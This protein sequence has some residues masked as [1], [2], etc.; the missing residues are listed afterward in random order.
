M[1]RSPLPPVYAITDRILSGVRDH[2]AIAERLF[3]VGVRLVQLRE[4]ESPDRDF[5]SAADR[6]VAAA[7]PYGARVVV[8]DRPDVAALSG[9]GV[10]LGEEDLP[11]GAARPLLAP[12]ALLGVS[13]HDEAAAAEAFRSDAP[14]YV[15]FGPVFPSG[16]KTL[17]EARGL[18]VLARVAAGKNRP[19]VAI[20]GIRPE[21]LRSVLDAGADSA[22]MVGALMEGGRLEENARR[23]LDEA[24]RGRLRGRIYLVGFMGSGKT[25]VG[26]RVAER[27]QVP[28]V[29]IDEEVE[30]T[31][32]LTV[33][34]LFEAA[35]EEEF[36]RRESVFLQG[37]ESIPVAVVAT[38]GGSFVRPENRERLRKLGTTVFLDPPFATIRQRLAGKTDRPLFQNAEQAE[39]LF[40]EREPFYKMA[41]RRV[42]L[43]GEE[44]VEEASDAVLA[45]VDDR[46]SEIQTIP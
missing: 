27:L 34:A 33:R 32:G 46:S 14:D 6:A 12:G 4:K 21:N 30:R 2:A 22:A 36:R 44:S 7:R 23:A 42:E 40:R 10:H 16:T 26:H 31:S 43:T 3:R 20:G 35:G 9:A 17:R 45:A 18:D 39:A 5:L 13:T 1:D 15:A 41:A 29:D 24:R 28:F 37:T 25:A 19:L 8:N 11:P 38:G